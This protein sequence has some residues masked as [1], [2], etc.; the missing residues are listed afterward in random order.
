M[1]NINKL[2]EVIKNN[3]YIKSFKPTEEDLLDFIGGSGK[4]FVKKNKKI[5]DKE[6]FGKDYDIHKRWHP[7]LDED[8]I[9]VYNEQFSG[10]LLIHPLGRLLTKPDRMI[11]DFKELLTDP[12]WSLKNN[13]IGLTKDALILNLLFGGDDEETNIDEELDNYEQYK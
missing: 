8:P 5:F 6:F 1:S 13:K 2:L 9:K 3:E 4:S 10:D 7:E 12:K 11:A